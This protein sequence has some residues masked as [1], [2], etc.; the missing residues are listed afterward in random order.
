M[1]VWPWERAQEVLTHYAEWART[2]PNEVSASA[3]L[4]Q[5]PPLPD[6][7][8]ILR[9]RQV[10][11]VDGAVLGNE[12]HANGILAG[13]RALEPEID[14]FGTVP[15]ASLIR[16][17]MDPEPP[18]PGMGDGVLVDD[19][20]AEAIAAIVATAGP[21]T[22]SPLIMVELRQLGG[23]LRVRRAGSGALGALDGSF[24]FYAVGVPMGPGA[25]E[26]IQGTDR[27]A[28]GGARPVVARQAVPQLRREA[29]SRSA[30][31]SAPRRSSGSR[32]S[33]R[34][35]TRAGVFRSAHRYE[36]ATQTDERDRI[37]A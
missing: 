21:G 19:L 36:A 15:A 29:A 11:V 24:A 22:D 12:E 3:R 18:M 30:T 7:P 27:G 33:R 2:A 23:A 17:H 8:E 16:L 20:D 25:A 10:V 35:S 32:G 6:I 26:A 34:R 28:E 37:A 14:T 4:L 1:M 9:G 5:I 31:P 13:F